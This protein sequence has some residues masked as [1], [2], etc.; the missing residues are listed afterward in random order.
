MVNII[1]RNSI[2]GI[3]AGVTPSSKLRGKRSASAN[4]SST[5]SAEDRVLLSPM[6]RD[7]QSAM[8]QFQELDHVR[9]DKVTQIKQQIAD[10]SYQIDTEKIARNIVNESLFNELL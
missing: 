3:T 1:D 2:A 6:A 5:G 7:I 4:T 9:D 8:N 10:G